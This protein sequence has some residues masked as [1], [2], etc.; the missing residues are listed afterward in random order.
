MRL[1]VLADA[2][3]VAD[4]HGKLIARFDLAHRREAELLVAAPRLMT[5]LNAVLDG[6]EGYVCEIGDGHPYW[7]DA[8]L[9]DARRFLDRLM[10]G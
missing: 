10:A 6:A 1:F 5:H 3:G 4:D 2:I 8:V 9:E 7:D